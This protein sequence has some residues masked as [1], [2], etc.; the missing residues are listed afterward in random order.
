MALT[1]YLVI[2]TAG[3]LYSAASG[4]QF[5]WAVIPGDAIHIVMLVLLWVPRSVRDFFAVHR[6]RRVAAAGTRPHSEREVGAG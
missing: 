4:T 5:L 1:A 6:S 3:S 2:A